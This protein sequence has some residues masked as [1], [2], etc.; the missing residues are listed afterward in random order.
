MWVR[1]LHAQHVQR[2]PRVH[3]RVASFNFGKRRRTGDQVD[4]EGND[5]VHRTTPGIAG[6]I[7]RKCVL[8]CGAP[9][10]AR[11]CSIVICVFWIRE[12]SLAMIPL[13]RKD[14]KV[15]CATE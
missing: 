6:T 2:F 1:M 4:S 7:T 10:C 14:S 15:S 12:I 9:R 8:C 11:N 5:L 13:A 3:R